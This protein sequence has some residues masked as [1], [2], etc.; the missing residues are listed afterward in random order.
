MSQRVPV[1]P[2][3]AVLV[4]AA[5]ATPA[6][7]AGGKPAGKPADKA[8]VAAP[9]PAPTPDP[10]KGLEFRNIGPAIMGGRIDDFAVVEANPAVFYVGTASG[11]ILKTTN[12][13]TTF[14]P[15]FDDQLVSTIGD[16]AL[17]PS[18]PQV[19]YVGTGEPNN[20]QS[21]SWGNGVYRTLDGGK[22]WQHLGLADT[23]HIG[24]VLVHPRDPGVV[25]VA[26][27]GRLWGP[28][29]E[30]GLYK[31][32]DGGKAW[33]NTKLVDED[34]GFVDVAMDPESPETLYAASYQRRRTPFGFGGG[35]PGSGI[36]KTVDGGATW[37]KLAKGLPEGEVGRIGLAVYLRDPRIVYAL[38]EHAKEGGVY[39]SEDRGETWAKVSAT[40]PRPSYY[41][42]IRIDPNNDRRI[43]VFGASMYF[44]DDGGKTFKTDLV[45]RIHG[46]FHAMWIDPADSNRML[47]GSDGGI[48]LSWDRGRTWDFVNTFPLAQLYEV[49][50][51][52]Q[53]PYHV[54]GGLQDNGSWSAPSRTRWRQGISNDEWVRVGGGD[55]FYCV[56]DPSDPDVV[57]LESQDGNVARLHRTSGQRRVIRPEPPAGEKYRFNWNSPILVSPHDPKTVYYGGN[58]LFGSRD[59]GDTWTLV[60]PDLT[61]TDN[62]RRDAMTIFGKPAKDLLSRNDGVRHFGTITAIAESPLEAGVLWA[63]TDD[64]NL[65]VSRDGGKTWTNVAA[66]VPGVPKGTYV[67]RVEASRTGEG[68][69]YVSFDGHR[70]NDFDPYLFFTADYGQTWKPVAG[71]LP[72]GGTISVVREHPKNPDVLFVGTERG[73]W[74]S[75]DRGAGWTAVRGKN[76]PTVPVDDLL[77]HPR[78]GD[79]V[80]GTHG[81]GV[82]VLDDATPLVDLPAARG[83]DLHLFPV[84]AATQWRL[85]DHK[86]DTGHKAFLAPNPPDGALLTYWL[87]AK[88]DEKA[89]AGPDEKASGS[90]D[91]RKP[92][93]KREANITVTDASGAVVRELKG[94]A[95][96]GIN[97]TSWD[98]RREPPVK[99]EE[100]AERSFMGPPRGPW[101]LPGTYTVKVALDGKEASQTVAVVDD[102]RI[103]ATDAERRAWNDAVV[104][105]GA[106]WARADAADKAAK[107]LKKQ[108]EELKASLGKK[109]DTPEAVTKGVQGLLDK[110]EPLRKRLT[111]ETPMGFAGAPLDADPEPLL[112]RAR[113]L[114]FGLSSYVAPPTAPQRAVIDRTSREVGE[115]AAA[116]K[117]IQQTDVPALNELI[118]ESGIG[119]IDAGKPLP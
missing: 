13:G 112:P 75:W 119:R 58:R 114:G 80:L 47:L 33:T 41:S 1:S 11:G 101:A 34:T 62:A 49:A 8:A 77:V 23:H 97:R 39:R 105:A 104:E 90:P 96:H 38:V 17:A 86:A 15:V 60:S 68:A 89:A 98:L 51:D 6:Q 19:L 67:S 103:T 110:V 108:L 59:R 81:R 46:D 115:V 65:Q 52:M 30:R 88:P 55:G 66:R 21:S 42:K 117:A 79:L 54:Y 82:Y 14:E 83:K 12:Y 45:D 70:G 94:P 100:G 91:E 4:L 2:L 18:D 61:G 95:E 74:A 63:G 44:S 76:L 64:G 32:T 24:R 107:S 48:H 9:A 53:S 3:V 20:R 87:A 7:P 71:N 113:S 25:Y 43:W 50:V 93:E 16:L 92:A 22:T 111:A 40:N 84:R 116:L 26:A 27:L 118:Y 10:L 102:P 5:S 72:A 56:P 36:W 57:Y 29:R 31:T 109:K 85:F 37:T 35:G 78:E 99:P 106:V 28:S 69:A 73:L